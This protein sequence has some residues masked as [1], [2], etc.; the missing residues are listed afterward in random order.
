MSKEVFNNNSSMPLIS[1]SHSYIIEPAYPKNCDVMTELTILGALRNDIKNWVLEETGCLP[2]IDVSE[3]D[4][5]VE[6][7]REAINIH[8][9]PDFIKKINTAFQDRI[10]KITRI[11]TRDEILAK[12]H[13][14][15]KNV[16]KP[17]F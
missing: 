15:L 5:N 13:P 1:S 2:S 8:C 16:P 7:S 4:P 14:W 6:G 12:K 3:L 17:P 10:K 11:P 9:T